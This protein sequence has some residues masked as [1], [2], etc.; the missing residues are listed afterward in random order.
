MTGRPVTGKAATVVWLAVVVIAIVVI[1]NARFPADLSAFL[2]T[3]P[4]PEQAPPPIPAASS[5]DIRSGFAA[6]ALAG[7]SAYSA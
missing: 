2:P 4:T 6:M 7:A 1:A 5:N 3:R